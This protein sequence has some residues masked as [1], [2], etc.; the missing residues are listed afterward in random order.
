MAGTATL[1]DVPRLYPT[2]LPY[3][4]QHAVL[5]TAQ[6]ILEECCF[7]FTQRWLLSVLQSHGW[8]CAAAVELTRWT[9]ILSQRSATL[10]AH[11]LTRHGPALAELLC[12]ASKLRHTA[13][14]RLPTTARGI[15]AFVQA[16]SQLATALQDAARAA[17]LDALHAELDRNIK[18][19][20][21]HKN[22]LEDA[23]SRHLQDICR[24]RQA[25]DQKEREAKAAMV[26]EDGENK[27]LV[28]SLLEE[29]VWRIFGAEGVRHQGDVQAHRVDPDGDSD[30][31]DAGYVEACEDFSTQGAS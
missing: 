24:Q 28:G 5:N 15:A 4:A 18:A 10:S 1:A 8:D 12:T 9:R 3:R 7:A 21:L 6:R 27:S 17:Q 20:E 31:D 22:A 23:L 14:H 26:R 29:S 19:M 16:A 13:V 30:D 2:Y 11:S 25:L